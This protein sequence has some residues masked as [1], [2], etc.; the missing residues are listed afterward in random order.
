MTSTALH[1]RELAA[2]LVPT[3]A[4]LLGGVVA[5]PLF[6]GTVVV[7]ALA[8]DDFDARIHP[9]SSLSLGDHGWV[10]VV[11]FVVSG[12][13]VL[14]F[15]V[16]LRRALRGTPAGRWGPILV[17]VNGAS[18]VVAGLFLADP[19]NGYPVGAV[20]GATVHGVVHAAAPAIGGLAGYAAYVVFARRFAKL[21]R[22]GWAVASVAIVPA[23]IALSAVAMAAGD[24]RIMLVALA[25]GMG[26][27]AAVA[28]HVLR[29]PER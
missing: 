15:A 21:G 2:P 9:L 7:Q 20:E 27:M 6:L 13:L 4:L 29:T 11:N 24:F 12:L 28:R 3:R 26:W 25:L 17:G 8:H 18:L 23:D 14:G 10:Q 1:S 22:R 16:G 19:I 5:G